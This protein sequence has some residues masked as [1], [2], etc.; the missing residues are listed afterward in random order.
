MGEIAYNTGRKVI[1]IRAR[2]RAILGILILIG[3]QAALYYA[4]FWF[5]GGHRKNLFWFII[6]S[7]AIFRGVFRSIAGW[8]IL[9]FVSIPKPIRPPDDWTVDV[10]TTAMPGEPF[11]M[12]EKTLTAI[13]KMSRA[14]TTYLLDGGNDPALLDLCRRLGVV[15]VNCMG[16]EGAKAGKINHCLKNFAKGEFVLVLDPDHIPRNDFLDRALEGFVNDEVGFVQ[17]VQAY[18]NNGSGA[19]AKAAS[20]QT[21]GFY[22]PQMMGLNGMKIPTAIGANCLFRRAALDSIGGHAV[23]LAEDANTSMR[24]H[25]KG[26]ESRY[27][28]YRGSYGLVPDDL[29]TFFKQQLKWSTGM[30]QLFLREYPKLFT[31]FN[32]QSKFYYLFAGTFY[33]QGFVTFLTILLPIIFLFFQVFAVEMPISEF[34]LHAAPYMTSI[35]LINFF[36]QR[37]YSDAGEHGMPLRSLFLEKGCWHIF[38]L[39]F[40]YTIIRKKVLYLPTSKTGGNRVSPALLVPHIVAVV[41]SIAAVIFA[42]TTYYRIDNGTILMIFFALVNTATLS[43]TIFWGLRESFAPGPETQPAMMPEPAQ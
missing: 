6:L 31:R 33:L 27:I 3:I 30:F 25:A 12:F 17:V 14:H 35:L 26:W 11:D 9:L 43:P 5:F 29:Q 18:Y 24:I 8:I 22:G 19:I 34:L 36:V 20:E 40:F 32:L 16:I 42:L 10:F 21:F 37:W 2:D 1:R 39:A 4:D 38:T 13:Q 23:D 28:P 7:Y 15:H 41:F